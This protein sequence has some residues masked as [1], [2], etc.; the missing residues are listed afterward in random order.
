M[1]KEG[2]L[3]IGFPFLNL[4]T[5]PY[6]DW[7][8]RIFVFCDFG[9]LFIGFTFVLWFFWCIMCVLSLPLSQQTAQAAMIYI[10]IFAFS[11]LVL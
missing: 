2:V 7:V 11:V 5:S 8:F 1:V 6:K 4:L 10:F 3:E 9:S